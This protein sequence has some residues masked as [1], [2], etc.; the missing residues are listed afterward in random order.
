MESI[1]QGFRKWA[2]SAIVLSVTWLG[3][4]T[5]QAQVTSGKLYR[6]YSTCGAG[7]KVMGISGSS[8]STGAGDVLV[9]R[10][11]SQMSQVFKIENSGSAFKI[12]A[13][14][15]GKVLAISGG[16]T[17]SS[18]KVVQATWT[19]SSDQLFAI[20][21]L[22]SGL[23]RFQNIKSGLY[24]DLSGANTTPGTPFIQYTQNSTC[25]Q[26]YKLEETV[27]TSTWTRCATE[28]GVCNFTG[29]R[30]VRYG[31]NGVFAYRSAT[32]SL[33]CNNLT[34]G[35]PVYGS[36]KFCD[37]SG[38]STSTS[39]TTTVP[40]V[41]TTTTLPVPP[42]TTTLP[43]PTTTTL[44]PAPTTTTLPSPTT[45]TTLPAPT[46]SVLPTPTNI[47]NGSTV[48]LQCG[49]TYQ[50]T[51]NLAGKSNVT[52]Q[53]L[54][55]CGKA[56]ITPGRAVT[57]WTL[58][59][60]GI[61]SAPISFN[62]VQVS[63]AGK[64]MESAHWPN[65]PQT[66]AAVGSAVPNSDVTGATLVYIDNLWTIR[67]E[68]LTSNSV[69]TAK[70]FYLEGKL[71]ML[72]APGEW[73][74]S[75]GRIYVWPSDGLSPEGRAWAS[76][77]SNGLN[78]NT[79]SRSITDLASLG[80][81]AN[82]SSGITINGV[83][84]F[85]A[86]DGISGAYST[87]LHVLNSEILNSSREGIYATD[88]AGL[89][90]DGNTITNSVRNGIGGWYTNTGG[91][92]TNNTVTN[93][94]MVG[95]PKNSQGAIAYGNTATNTFID[96]NRVSNCS[97]NGISAYVGSTIS[98]NVID[99]TNLA[100]P[101]GGGI[102]TNGRTAGFVPLNLT[103]KGNTVSNVK[104]KGSHAIYL[105]DSASYVTITGNQISNNASGVFIHDGSNNQVVSNS[106]S[107][108]FSNHAQLATTSANNHFS[109]N[110]FNS[111]NNELTY[112]LDGS[113]AQSS[114][115]ATYDNNIYQSTNVSRFASSNGAYKSYSAWKSYTGQDVHSTMNGVP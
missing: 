8:V 96:H 79:S 83:K 78:S 85:S 76:T 105:D 38:L 109:G 98:N 10:D 84:V 54:G 75:N 9:A 55:T 34:F 100:L 30:E 33:A 112:Q 32:G 80:I 115:Y 95:M 46:G 18:A 36:T 52:V 58:Y 64:P 57:G 110:S 65:K 107:S 61:Y 14:H 47:P 48:S 19:G 74:L 68:T 23:V 50:G 22:T 66:W 97:Y 114:S 11:F 49:T 44:P 101:D 56:T 6:I 94:G 51:L 77:D 13:Q 71:W 111:T 5:V 62:P 72:D 41:T 16:S 70:P 39:T 89:V 31:A 92:I 2:L 99:S 40:V 59:Q 20:K 53:T 1:F 60:G 93:V 82:N 113:N 27:S 103:I 28:G 87:N 86:S 73:A 29:T 15:S 26:R 104:T 25:A 12:T 42:P 81:N 17:A 24:I 90:I 91:R 7:D 67:T 45:T 37:Y 21:T 108:N 88:A 3:A 35:D 106:F 43:S 63:V 69:S 102:Y 4:S